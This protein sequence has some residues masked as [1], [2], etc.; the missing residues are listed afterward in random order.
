MRRHGAGE[1][2]PCRNFLLSRDYL[3][4][5]VDFSVVVVVVSDELPDDEL[6]LDEL[7]LEV[8]EPGLDE[9]VSE[10]LLGGVVVVLLPLGLVVVVVELELG[11]A[12][13]LLVVV[14]VDVLLVSR[15]SV[16]L[17]S[18]QA[19]SASVASAAATAT[20][21]ARVLR[22]FILRSSTV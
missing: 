21:I 22:C 14:V 13:G 5:V 11:D 19:P 2:A 7:G 6:G 18:E 17:R 1:P 8:D 9:L 4:F 16:R 12:P 3:V 10:L 20:P 15:P